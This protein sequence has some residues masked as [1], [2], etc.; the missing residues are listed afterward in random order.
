MEYIFY[1]SLGDSSL[2]LRILV[3]LPSFQQT[4]SFELLQ[5]PGGYKIQKG[6]T[7]TFPHDSHLIIEIGLHHVDLSDDSKSIQWLVFLTSVLSWHVSVPKSV[8]ECQI[9]NMSPFCYKIASFWQSHYHLLQR[10]CLL[11]NLSCYRNTSV[12]PSLHL[13]GHLFFVLEMSG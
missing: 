6:K 3:Q 4:R 2:R 13:A 11:R 12:A 1:D 5:L 10:P 9:C 7:H 8:L